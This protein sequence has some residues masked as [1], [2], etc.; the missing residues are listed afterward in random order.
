MHSSAAA[1]AAVDADPCAA[2]TPAQACGNLLSS[3]A[4]LPLECSQGC[5]SR[6]RCS[7][8]PTSRSQHSS[9]ASAACNSQRPQPSPDSLG[10]VPGAA[11]CITSEHMLSQLG[12]YRQH[13]S[14]FVRAIRLNLDLNLDQASWC[15]MVRPYNPS[16]TCGPCVGSSSRAGSACRCFLQQRA[17][18]A[19]SHLRLTLWG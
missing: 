6:G 16:D 5:C 8:E 7:S 12:V 11:G 10:Q 15:V 4:D 3:T 19:L 14:L 2:C 9:S 13:V 17:A 18:A 1:A